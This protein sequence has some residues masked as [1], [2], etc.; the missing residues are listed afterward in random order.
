VRGSGNDQAMPAARPLYASLEGEESGSSGPKGR[1]QV[2]DAIIDATV[3]L[4]RTGGPDKV[5]LRRVAENA[6][7]NYGL[8]HRHF[9]TKA[10]LVRAAM[11]RAH[12]RSY[13]ELVEPSDDLDTALA[14]ILHESTN[15]LARVMAW[16]ILQGDISNV[17]P[18]EEASMIPSGLCE[19]ATDSSAASGDVDPLTTK[20]RVGTLLASLLGWR[21]FEPYLIR[22]LE[23]ENVDMS[24]I[25]ES[26]LGELQRFIH[27]DNHGHT[28]LA[29]NDL[30]T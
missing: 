9:G 26:I 6:N 16:G 10:A 7:V 23:L 21:L 17:L 24:T 30:S 19:L 15:T 11:Q 14:R 25:Y 1:E 18:A 29:S 13:R 28:C 2:I 27:D 12:E 5:R 20:T 3:D 22:G 8:V 4:C